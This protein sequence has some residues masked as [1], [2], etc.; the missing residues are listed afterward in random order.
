VLPNEA[1]LFKRW[2]SMHA[3]DTLRPS[4]IGSGGSM[5]TASEHTIL[6]VLIGSQAHGLAGPDSDADYRGVFVIPTAWLFRLDFKYKGSRWT[7]GHEDETY[8]EIGRF[9][10]LATHGHPLV[11]ETFL[12]P[13][14]TADP[15]GQ[16]L[17]A[18]FPAAWQPQSAYEAFVSYALNQ[19]KKLLEKK[20]A[21]PLKYALAYL[22]VLWNLCELLQTGSFTVR[23]T[24][25]PFG[26]TLVK[27]KAG[28]FSTGQIVDT[29]ERLIQEATRHLA[30][31]THQPDHEAVNAFLIR[32]RTAFLA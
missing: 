13:V 12:A 23:V 18:L 29:G 21:R 10:S 11:L 7:E 14:V 2:P 27:V 9:L 15:W 30:L 24:E 31:C 6:K 4:E 16:E 17:L 32:L 19:R 20:D 22:R 5:A 1:I 25:T 26:E 8:W 3:S 28:A